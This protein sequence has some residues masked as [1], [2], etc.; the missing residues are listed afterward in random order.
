[1]LCST[2]T[3]QNKVPTEEYHMT[4]L[5]VQVDCQLGVVFQ[6]YYGLRPS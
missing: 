4:I 6:L 3:G 2:D 5:W 1:M